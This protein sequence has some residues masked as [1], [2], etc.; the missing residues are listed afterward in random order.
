VGVEPTFLP[1]H[2]ALGMVAVGALLGTIAAALGL[3][4]L[5]AV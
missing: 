4:R 3:R 2:I 1:W 5:V